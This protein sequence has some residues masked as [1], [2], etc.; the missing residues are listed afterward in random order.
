MEKLSENGTHI[1]LRNEFPVQGVA[2]GSTL[3]KRKQG[4]SAERH[5]G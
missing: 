2:D 1:V 3:P 4:E 5:C